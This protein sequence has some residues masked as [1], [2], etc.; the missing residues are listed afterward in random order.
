MYDNESLRNGILAFGSRL[1][2]ARGRGACVPGLRLA[3]GRPRGLE[4]CGNRRFFGVKP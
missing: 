3:G 2:I 1:S 4:R